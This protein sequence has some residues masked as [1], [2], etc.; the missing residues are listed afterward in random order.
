MSDEQ[1]LWTRLEQEPP[2]W[3]TYLVL[4]DLMEEQGDDAVAN[5][6][7]WMAEN[8]KRPYSKDLGFSDHGRWRWYDEYLDLDGHPPSDLPSEHFVRLDGG[9]RLGER[10]R[11]YADFRSATLALCEALH[12]PQE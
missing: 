12:Q 8:H 9:V 5:G 4:A 3:T 11:L 10:I 7:R 6:L 1:A 2:D